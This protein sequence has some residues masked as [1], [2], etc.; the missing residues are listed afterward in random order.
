MLK[1]EVL[2]QIRNM[3]IENLRKLIGDNSNLDRLINREI[4]RKKTSGVGKYYSKAAM[5]QNTNVIETPSKINRAKT[6]YSK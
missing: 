5:K 3:S 6:W 2:E 4:S 1:R